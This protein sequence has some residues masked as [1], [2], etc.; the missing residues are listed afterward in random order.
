MYSSAKKRSKT[1]LPYY[2][3]V[4]GHLLPQ[5]RAMA[6]AST[7]IIT[8]VTKTSSNRPFVRLRTYY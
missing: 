1:S 5:P 7:L 4:L 3:Q 8:N 2:Y 6:L